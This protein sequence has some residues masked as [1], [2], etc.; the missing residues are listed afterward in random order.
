MD[1][2]GIVPHGG[3]RPEFVRDAFYLS[4]LGQKPWIVLSF[5]LL[6]DAGLVVLP[7]RRGAL[8]FIPAA[9]GLVVFLLLGAWNLSYLSTHLLPWALGYFVAFAA[10]HTAI[11]IVLRRFSSSPE[12]SRS[13]QIF[14][15]L[16]LVLMLWP[17]LRIGSSTLLWGAILLVDLAAIALAAYTASMLG[18]VG[19]LV[20]T[21][22]AAGLWLAQMPAE[23][24]DL[25][26]LLAVIGGFAALFCMASAFLQRRLAPRRDT[27]AKGDYEHQ[28]LQFLPPVSAA[29][30]FLLLISVVERLNL[31]N[32]SPVFG[33][34]LLLIVMLLALARWSENAALPLV[35]LGCGWLLENAWVLNEY[36]ARSGPAWPLAFTAVFSVFP[37]CFQPR[38]SAAIMPWVTGALVAPLH[39]WLI[40]NGV[41]TLWPGF[42]KMAAGLV[43]AALAVPLLAGMEYH[44]RTFPRD[45]PARLAVLAWYGGAALFFITLIFPAQ[46]EREWLTISWALEGAALLWLW[47]RLPHQG[48]KITGF[49]LLC[50]VF[51]RLTLNSA[52][53]GYHPRSGV[54]IANWYLYTYGIPAAALFLSGRLVWPPRHRLWSM[55]IAAVLCTLGTILSFILLNIEVA[56]FFASGPTLT[57][58]FT[59]SLARD[60]T[61]SIAWSLYAFVMLF[62][63]MA[64][65]VSAIRYGG[66]ALLVVTLLKLFLH[67]LASLDQLY[68]IGAFIAVAIVLMGASYLY[69]R[70]LGGGKKA[71]AP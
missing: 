8:N 65:R 48:L 67:D 9:G 42:W 23:T 26:G 11:P 36:V 66:I 39:Y 32:P 62:I 59:G 6:A 2:R 53:L 58:D 34:G 29:L 30:P 10:F 35:G 44:R 13:A 68:R 61:Y 57:F 21:L 14:Q 17:A 56:D 3:L 15:S 33:V 46:F 28:A 60:M 47:H 18:V 70:F 41:A 49:C 51:I 5:A 64:R 25:A 45:S 16:S 50:L 63:G 52:V 55:N 22:L 19:A 20:L 40:A 24:P 54:P 71:E 4:D 38:K 1:N 37:F 31:Q 12:S 43:P 69:Q 27:D 7:V